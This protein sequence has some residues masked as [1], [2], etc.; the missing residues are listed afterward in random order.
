MG[1]DVFRVSLLLLWGCLF[2]MRAYY[3]ARRRRVGARVPRGRHAVARE[4]IWNVAAQ[5]TVFL[6][7]VS[8]LAIYVARPE[9][10]N[11]L[12]LPFPRWV[13]WAGVLLGVLSLLL[14]V[15]V[16]ETLGR[17]WSMGLE[18]REQHAL[19]TA[20]PYRWVRH[21]MYSA[22]FAFLVA[23]CLI[24]ANVMFLLGTA[25]SVALV[26]RRIPLEEAMLTGRFGDEYLEYMRNSG[27]FWPRIAW[28]RRRSDK[29]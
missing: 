24:S 22:L 27:R 26:Y 15:W 8:A 5:V 7:L 25:I 17:Q 16:Q 6:L 13:R 14:L 10:M 2:G 19:V 3:A 29:G 18:L 12:T 11:P 1:E 20:G 4:G 21:P 23:Q 28:G 9:W